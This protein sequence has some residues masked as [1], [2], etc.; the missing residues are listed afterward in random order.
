MYPNTFLGL[1][2]HF[3]KEFGFKYAQNGSLG[4]GDIIGYNG[5]N[6]SAIGIVG[7]L[8]SRDN[9]INAYKGTLL[10]VSTYFYRRSLGS[11]FDF[12]YLN[13][14]FQKYW[15]LKP[16]Q[17]F[18]IQ[19][20]TRLGNGDVPFLDM[21]AV[22]NDDLL[23]GYPKN[24]FRDVNFLGAQAEYRFPLFWRLGMVVFAGAGDV[25]NKASD[26]TITDLKWSIGSGLRLIVNP[27]ER[28]NVRLDYGY[29]KEGGYYYLVVAESF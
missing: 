24:R 15:Q 27:Q 21:S 23:R 14:T 1:D 5:G 19:A 8:D 7:V 4:K 26:L 6:Q 16:K 28:L 9:V 17:V 3:E 12:F 29:G 20:K 13:A 25:F 2:Y 22:G 10:E 18:A 11:T